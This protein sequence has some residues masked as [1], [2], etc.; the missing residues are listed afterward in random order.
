M[1][2]SRE[3]FQR[4]YKLS[5]LRKYDEA[6]ALYREVLK[7]DPSYS[8]AWNNLGWILYDQK[9]I[10]DEAEKCYNNALKFDENNYNALNNL[11]IIHYR[12]KKGY[13]RAEI[14]WKKAVKINPYFE[15]CWRNLSVL[16]KFQ[17]INVKK[18][19][20]CEEKANKIAKVENER[21]TKI[22]SVSEIDPQIDVCLECGHKIELGQKICDF[23][24]NQ[25]KNE[26]NMKN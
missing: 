13:K 6:A 22:K 1:V 5:D 19:M 25:F 16:Y 20:E 10:V 24:G 3:L 26:T 14:L 21:S 23:C 7:I 18:S 9:D 15:E 17:L 4:A 11:A 2:G 8:M 12:R